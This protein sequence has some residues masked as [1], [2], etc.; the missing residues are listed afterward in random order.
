VNSKTYHWCPN[1][2]M[3]C[4]HTPAD[5]KGHKKPETVSS[6][7]STMNTEDDASETASKRK[8]ELT[9]AFHTFIQ[10][11]DDGDDCI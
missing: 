11:A 1:H 6:D 8:M 3:W 9:T 4:I 5:C 10:D 2:V 7:V